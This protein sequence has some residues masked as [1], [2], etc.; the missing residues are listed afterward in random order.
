MNARFSYAITVLL[1][2]LSNTLSAGG[3]VHAV[4]TSAVPCV[5]QNETSGW[6]NVVSATA[7]R[8]HEKVY[9][10]GHSEENPERTKLKYEAMREVAVAAAEGK[11]LQ[12]I[13]KIALEAAVRIVGV[14]AGA[15]ALY[16][17]KG[18][19]TDS[20]FG[21]S[22][23]MTDMMSNLQ[24]KLISM[25]RSDFAVE[26]LFLTF[27]RGSKHS[28]FSYPLKMAGRNLGTI[29]GVTPGDRNLSVEEEFI[30][31]ITSLLSL[32]IANAS[33]VQLAGV[34]ISRVKSEAYAE[35]AVAVNHYVNNPLQAIMGNAELL[36]RDA[37]KLDARTVKLLTGIKEAADRI[38]AVTSKLRS[39]ISHDITD[40][41]DGIKMLNLG[42]ETDEENTDDTE[43][44]SQRPPKS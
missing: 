22:Q 3:L 21:G 28:M 16:D 13:C 1:S 32:A 6:T 17:E 24:E 30:S 25:L 4:W 31:A 9:V 43:G 8:L 35:T 29:S 33:G 36:L 19:Q 26:S 2:I 41:V 11:N 14:S 37:G 23:D 10:N 12:E 39:Q 7:Y 44:K 20:F 40:Y 5:S 15:I 34:D 42:D 27:D 38:D 18:K